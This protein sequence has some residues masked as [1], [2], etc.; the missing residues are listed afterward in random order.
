MSAQSASRVPLP[1]LGVLVPAITPLLPD[2]TPDLESLDR[3]IDYGINSGLD[4]FL[5]L[6]STGESV[7]LSAVERLQVATRAVEYARGRTHLMI[8]VPALGTKDQVAEAVQLDAL[9]P[10]SLLVASPGGFGLSQS[11]LGG[12]FRTIAAAVSTPVVVYEVPSRVGVSLDAALIAA[13]AAD[14]TV[15]GVK[16]SSG[17]LVRGRGVSEATRQFP[18]FIRY[19]GCE[20]CIDGAMLGGYNGAVAGLANVFPE[21]HVELIRRAGAGDWAGASEIQG[22]IMSLLDLYFHPLANA[23]FNGQF[24]AIVKEALVQKGVI[25]H[26]TASAPM[27][28]GD[29]GVRTHVRELLAR[30]ADLAQSFAAQSESTRT[31]VPANV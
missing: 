15:A 14:G 6:G 31:A 16:D 21:F 30:G 5:L 17:D 9:Q 10:D 24:F 20:Q 23:S 29:E 4:G 27:T 12:H 25:A 1:Q 8:G 22:L 11:E 2:G 13:L 18:G 26:N 3:V 19:T 7:P 28:A